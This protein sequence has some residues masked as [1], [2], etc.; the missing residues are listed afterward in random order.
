M[1]I[2]LLYFDGCPT[3]RSA[4]EDLRKILVEEGV[5]AEVEMVAVNSDEEARRLRFPGSPTLRIDGR[6]PF[7]VSEPSEGRNLACRVYATPEG[8][9]GAPTTAMFREALGSAEEESPERRPL[10]L[11][12]EEPVELGG[13]FGVPFRT[14]LSRE[15][16]R[17]VLVWTQTLLAPLFT[18][19]LYI[20]VFGYGL[21]SRIRE[22]AGVPY[23]EFIL[24]GLVLMSVITG[25]YGN[26]ST[27]LFDAKRERYIDDVLISPMTPL[28]IALAYV[29]GGVVR[30]LVVGTGT[31]ALAVP[32][33]GLPAEHPLLLLVTALAT[34]VIFASLGVVAG[35]LATRID[36][37]FF[38]T[39]IV[40]QP[41][42]FL[43]GIFYSVETLPDPLRVVTYFNPVFYAIDAFRFAALGV[44]DV[45]AYPALAALVVFAVLAFLGTTEMLRRGH[46]LRY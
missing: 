12:D 24:P 6:D 10:T 43:G 5:E 30:G 21:G 27:S 15:V 45:P 23:L 17:F 35:V 22:A 19:A 13:V 37:I 4:E 31:F 36:H 8:M 1:R 34:S 16:R 38:L 3:Y 29:L 18:S 26:T 33:A 28:Q 25:S 20:L 14:L 11:G 41:L 9:K 40:I 7:P 39:N 2:E 44:S 42:A 46:N 32:L